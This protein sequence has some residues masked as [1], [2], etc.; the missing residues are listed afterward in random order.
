MSH[1]GRKG[2]PL[3][4]VVGDWLERSQ[5]RRVPK[6]ARTEARERAVFPRRLSLICGS[7]DRRERGDYVHALLLEVMHGFGWFLVLYHSKRKRGRG[8]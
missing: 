1:K 5:F 2:R 3:A 4:I 8:M 6:K 7:L